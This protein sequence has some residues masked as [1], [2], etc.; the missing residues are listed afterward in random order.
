MVATLLYRFLSCWCLSKF[1]FFSHSQISCAVCCRYMISWKL[2]SNTL[3]WKSSVIKKLLTVVNDQLEQK[4]K[5]VKTCTNFVIWQS[6]YC[7]TEIRGHSEVPNPW[8]HTEVPLLVATV[9]CQILVATPKCQ[10]LVATLKC[11]IL[12]HP[13]VPHPWGHTKVPNP[14]GHSEVPHL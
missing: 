14:W 4:S 2:Y 13:E 11:Q 6:C 7:G 8:G 10:I 9:K 1:A 12:G 5:V 3:I